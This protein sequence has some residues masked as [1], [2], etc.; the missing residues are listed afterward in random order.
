MPSAAWFAYTP[1]R[2]GIDPQT[3]LANSEDELQAHAY[4]SF[5]ALYVDDTIQEAG[6]WAH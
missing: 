2:K 3:Y 4:G 1:D 5:N 6:C